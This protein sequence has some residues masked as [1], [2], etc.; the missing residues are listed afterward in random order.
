VNGLFVCDPKRLETF[1]A[2]DIVGTDIFSRLE[3]TDE[4]FEIC[5]QGIAFPIFDIDNY[6]FTIV[7]RHVDSPSYLTLSN[8]SGK[9]FTRWLI[10]SDTGKLLL[11]G[12]SNLMLWDPDDQDRI[13]NGNHNENINFQISP[14]DYQV[15][16]VGAINILEI[17]EEEWVL[18]LVFS[19]ITE[20]IGQEFQVDLSQ[21]HFL[22]ENKVTPI[23]QAQMESPSTKNSVLEK[24]KASDETIIH[25]ILPLLN[26][27]VFSSFIK[28]LFQDKHGAF[29]EIEELGTGFF[30]KPWID[31]YGESLETAFILQ[32]LPLEI[33]KNPET[34]DTSND[35]ILFSQLEKVKK[36]YHKS[37]G[38]FGMV[39]GHLVPATKLR[40]LGF[41]T[42]MYDLERQEYFEKLIPNYVKVARKAG[43]YIPII[44]GSYDSFIDLNA[45]RTI[46]TLKKFLEKHSDGL[47][48]NF[49]DSDVKV[50]R[51]MSERNLGGVLRHSYQICEPVLTKL[52]IGR[53]LLSEFEM[54]IRKET[55]EKDLEDFLQAHYREIFGYNYDR[56]ETQVWL[57]FPNLDLVGKRRRLDIF[58]RNGMCQ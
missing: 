57:K 9:V 50:S 46:E 31:S 39:S 55:K 48:I 42:N 43:I 20:K 36:H 30:R 22:Q 40:T 33:F 10:N 8:R 16:V 2:D 1:F 56:I 6:N 53:S 45:E 21:N 14:G 44:L 25:Q 51:F 38:A 34:F 3:T 28:E 37:S 52:D 5:K 12:L 11:C 35:P 24:Q 17:D 4:I 13:D 15:E 41:L 47:T 23:S 19:P 54:L 27:N 58:L 18:E 7:V 32:Y 29:L 26:K 49:S